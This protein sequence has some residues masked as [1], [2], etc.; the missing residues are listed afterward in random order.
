MIYFDLNE[1]IRTNNATI[2]RAS[3]DNNIGEAG[4]DGY[5]LYP[6]PASTYIYVDQLEAGRYTIYNSIGQE[7]GHYVIVNGTK[8]LEFG[9]FSAG[10][11]SIRRE[12]GE[13]YR[14]VVE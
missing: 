13:V 11:Y 6:N 9:N 10:I 8:K 1:P 4:I 2:I 14:F 12:N 3:K 7:M 5:R